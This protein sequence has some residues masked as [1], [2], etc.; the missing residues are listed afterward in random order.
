MAANDEIAAPHLIDPAWTVGLEDVP[1][2]LGLRQVKCRP[3]HHEVGVDVITE[4]P[5]ATRNHQFAPFM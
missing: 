1:D 2:T 4:F 3:G 5:D